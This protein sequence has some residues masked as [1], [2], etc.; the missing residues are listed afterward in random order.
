VLG[1]EQAW[2]LPK[3]REDFAE[4]WGER[5]PPSTSADRIQ[6]QPAAQLEA[7]PA[8]PPRTLQQRWK[9]SGELGDQAGT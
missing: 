8:Q 4:E 5:A 3:R 1:S 6:N 2:H 9:G 7:S